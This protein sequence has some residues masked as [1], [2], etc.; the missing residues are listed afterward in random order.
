[1]NEQLKPFQQVLVRADGYNKWLA[2]FYSHYDKEKNV[3]ICTNGAI[4]TDCIPYE[5]NEALLGT[6]DAPQ[7][8]RWRAKKGEWYYFVASTS[9]VIEASDSYEGWDN[10]RYEA[11]NYFCSRAVAQAIADRFKAML[12]GGEG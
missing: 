8:K 4:C 10:L 6:T 9:I 1:M 11:G 2:S 5:G 7:S 12:K 3:H